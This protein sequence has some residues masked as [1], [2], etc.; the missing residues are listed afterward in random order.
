MLTSRSWRE[1]SRRWVLGQFPA[2]DVPLAPE[3]Q[4]VVIVDDASPLALPPVL[5]CWA[6]SGNITAVVGQWTQTIIQPR[7]RPIIVLWVNGITSPMSSFW[8]VNDGDQSALLTA[9]TSQRIQ[10]PVG[11]AVDALSRLG[12]SATNLT[13]TTVPDVFAG[14]G[15]FDTGV[16]VLPGQ[17]FFTQSTIQNLGQYIGLVWCEV[18]D[19]AWLTSLPRT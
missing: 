13:P 8:G 2:G 3:L 14:Q 7:V 15:R 18:P 11:S 12:T 1:W 5:A 6:V 9:A 19:E 17:F 4:P 10:G 16:I